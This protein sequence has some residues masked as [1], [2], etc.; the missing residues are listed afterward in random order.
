MSQLPDR[1]VTLLYYYYYYYYERER[2]SERERE[3]REL[4][5][6]ERERERENSLPPVCL[7]TRHTCRSSRQTVLQYCQCRLHTQCRERTH[8]AHP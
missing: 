5:E 8:T 4:S 6:R 2:E 1:A 3:M 7:V